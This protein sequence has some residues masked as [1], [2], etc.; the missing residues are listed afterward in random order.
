MKIQVVLLENRIENNDLYERRDTLVASGLC[1]PVHLSN[2]RTFEVAAKLIK[3]KL[4]IEVSLNVI[5]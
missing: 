4:N 2:E 3:D 1:V 5:D